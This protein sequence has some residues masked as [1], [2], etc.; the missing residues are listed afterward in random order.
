MS[1]REYNGPLHSPTP[2]D[3]LLSGGDG[4]GPCTSSVASGRVVTDT[5]EPS[6]GGGGAR[7]ACS[8]SGRQ[9]R[10]GRG[11]TGLGAAQMV[12]VLSEEMKASTKDW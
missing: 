8:G 6:D 2:E 11:V 9:G 5:L 7:C 4:V 12:A 3:L 1:G 10:W